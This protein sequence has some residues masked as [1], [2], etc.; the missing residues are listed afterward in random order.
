MSVRFKGI[1]TSS[2][3]PSV[4]N[5]RTGSVDRSQSEPCTCPPTTLSQRT[6]L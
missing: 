6:E 5:S 4:V 3:A 2:V 1:V